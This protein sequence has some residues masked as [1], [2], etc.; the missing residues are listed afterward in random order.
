MRDRDKEIEQKRQDHLRIMLDRNKVPDV[1]IRPSFISDE[2]RLKIK[3]LNRRNQLNNN[4]AASLVFGIVAIVSFFFQ[5]ST[6]GEI[7]LS[8]CIYFFTGCLSRT[9]LSNRLFNIFHLLILSSVV[10]LS[11]FLNWGIAFGLCSVYLSVSL[12]SLV[13]GGRILP[14]NTEGTFG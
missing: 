7:S 13:E 11:F 5:I 8:I 10:V 4:L 12:I 2:D 6:L 14:S 1:W 3:S 9:N